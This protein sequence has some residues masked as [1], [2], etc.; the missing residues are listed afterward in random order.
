MVIHQAND[1]AQGVFDACKEKGVYAFGAN[2]D[3]SSNPSGVVIASAYIVAMPAYVQLAQEVKNGTYKGT[4]TLKGMSDGVIAFG[5]N[6]KLADKV[7]AA[8]SQKLDELTRQI[9]DGSLV[10]PKDE[11]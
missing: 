11:F 1:R 5:L 3:Q 10:V 7:P 6:P 8:V 9:L 2:L 4:I